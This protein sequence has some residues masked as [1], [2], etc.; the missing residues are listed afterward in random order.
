MAD[1]APSSD[2][3]SVL[4]QEF[5]VPEQC[6]VEVD[7]PDVRVRLRPAT[8]PERV[9]VDVTV[10]GTRDA[11][12]DTVADRMG[13]GTRQVQDTIRI[14]AAPPQAQSDWW[15]WRRRT[16]AQVYLDVQVPSPIDASVRVP[17]GTLVA[18]GLEG[19]FDLSVPGGAVR[20]E[21]LRGPVALRA[22]RSAVEIEEVDGPRLSL[23]SAAAPLQ[24]LDIQSDELSIE[25]TAAPVT[26]QRARGTC[27]ITAHAAPVSLTE[28][29]GP[30]QAVAHRGSLRFEGPLRADTSLTTIA[31]PLTVRL[32]SSSGAALDATGTAVRLDDAFSFSGDRT[33]APLQGL[34]NG[35]G[36]ALTLRAVRGRIDCQQAA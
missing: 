8:T 21:R 2:T 18:S 28:L 15:R 35:G 32:P 3:A 13:L 7:V 12:A 24:L 22:R 6:R 14:V 36:P 26:V 34:L 33:A 25:A 23:Q 11:G 29:S 27:E 19:T 17:G 9:S 4:A 10:E 5:K 31:D 16:D 30:C 1:P 20:L